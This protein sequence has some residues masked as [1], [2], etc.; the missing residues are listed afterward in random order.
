MVG[1]TWVIRGTAG[2]LPLIDNWC[3]ASGPA[4]AAQP[5]LQ[6]GH[7]YA[8]ELTGAVGIALGVERCPR[9]ALANIR[10]RVGSKLEIVDHEGD[11]DAIG[12]AAMI[13]V[14][15]DEDATVFGRIGVGVP[16]LFRSG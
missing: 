6:I 1:G 14:A 12:Y 5:V 2:H 11:V 13:G 16:F 15:G 10:R 7:V 9:G 8:V 3:K 4:P